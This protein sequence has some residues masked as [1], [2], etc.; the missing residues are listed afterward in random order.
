MNKIVSTGISAI[1][2]TVI[3]Y[4]TYNRHF[5]EPAEEYE[6]PSEID[7][8]KLRHV[9]VHNGLFFTKTQCWWVDDGYEKT[10]HNIYY[11]PF[12]VKYNIDETQASNEV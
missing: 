11:T 5:V 2:G 4:H 9:N 10:V 3:G 12:K 7:G 6:F 8:L 1:F